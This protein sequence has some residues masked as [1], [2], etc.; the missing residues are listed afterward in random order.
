MWK[1]QKWRDVTDETKDALK[2]EDRI[3][4]KEPHNAGHFIMYSGIT[5]IYYR[6][7]VG[8]VFMKPL[9][10][11]GTTQKLF[12]PVSWFSSYFTFLPLGDASICSEKIT[13]P[14]EK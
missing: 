3:Y 2:K 1:E 4:T 9:H 14:G 12:F 8:H 6:K 11:E 10:I 13:A 7:T 5:K